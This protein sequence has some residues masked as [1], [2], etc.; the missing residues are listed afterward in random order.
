MTA[1]RFSPA[2]RTQNE[3]FPLSL[4]S[5]MDL[6]TQALRD[7][8]TPLAERMRPQHLAEVVGQQHLLAEGC[9]LQLLIERDQLSSLI[10]WGPPGTGKTTLA[11]VIAQ[12]TRS[13]FV[14]FSA[15]M[16]GVKDIRHIVERAREDRALYSMQTIL[17][18]DE[19]HRFNKSQQDASCPCGT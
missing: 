6:F 12:R 13:R 14:F 17:F 16:H 5:L 8:Q 2:L 4:L 18:V 3:R 1:S 9:P 11:Q 15:I 7:D 10:F 19:I